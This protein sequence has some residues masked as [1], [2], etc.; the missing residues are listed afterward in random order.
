MAVCGRNILWIKI[1][2]TVTTLCCVVTEIHIDE[3]IHINST[4]CWNSIL[5][6][7]KLWFPNPFELYSKYLYDY[8]S[9]CILVTVMSILQAGRCG[10]NCG[11][12]WAFF[13]FTATRRKFG[14]TLRL[15]QWLQELISPTFLISLGEDASKSVGQRLGN[16]RGK[17]QLCRCGNQ[18]PALQ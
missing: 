14:P 15:V 1:K 13:F 12:S 16:A 3:I 4:G 9:L 18:T 2:L 5:V 6:I 7:S 10:F 8:W 11:R 17:K